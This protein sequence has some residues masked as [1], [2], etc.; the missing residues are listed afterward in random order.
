MEIIKEC[1]KS[2]SNVEE[3]ER[4]TLL[5]LLCIGPEPGDLEEVLHI[6]FSFLVLFLLKFLLFHP[7]Q[8]ITVVKVNNS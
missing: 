5:D 2:I 3:D 4:E 6:S 8:I 7:I 1:R